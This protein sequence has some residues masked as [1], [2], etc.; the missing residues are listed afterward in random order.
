MMMKLTE[1]A[2]KFL[3]MHLSHLTMIKCFSLVLI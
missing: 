3:A 2:I 1:L